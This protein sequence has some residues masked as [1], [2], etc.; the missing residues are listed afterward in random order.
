MEDNTS[1]RL[2]LSKPSLPAVH[3]CAKS[4]LYM[5]GSGS[6]MGVQLSSDKAPSAISVAPLM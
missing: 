6:N 3:C 2:S 1:L 4:H 5:G